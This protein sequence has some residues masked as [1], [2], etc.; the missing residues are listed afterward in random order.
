MNYVCRIEI[1]IAVPAV[2]ELSTC[3]TE[4]ANEKCK[5]QQPPSVD[6]ISAEDDP[7]KR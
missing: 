7:K 6:Q 5:R 3:E 1:H 4:N 2:P